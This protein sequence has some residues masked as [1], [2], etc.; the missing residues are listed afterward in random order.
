M[1]KDDFMKLLA[2]KKELDKIIEN[3]KGKKES[4]QLKRIKSI[5]ESL[6]NVLVS[7]RLILAKQKQK[8]FFN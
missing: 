7:E 4:K 8:F 3:Y 6:N 2:V 1:L 5:K